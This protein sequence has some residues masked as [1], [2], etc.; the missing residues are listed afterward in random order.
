VS[1]NLNVVRA[2]SREAA[3]VWAETD[4]CASCGGYASADVFQWVKL[5]SEGHNLPRGSSAVYL[6]YARDKPAAAGLRADTRDAHLDWLAASGRV[7][8][9]G[10]LLDADG[11]AVGSLLAV[12]GEGL[13]DVE[14]WAAADPYAAA[15][16]FGETVVALAPEM[17]T[18]DSLPLYAW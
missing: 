14:A 12:S 9:A 6:I 1:A 16:V 8:M 11:E 7:H 4:P 3:V 2:S 10:P 5:D 17:A 13:A 18:M 15:G